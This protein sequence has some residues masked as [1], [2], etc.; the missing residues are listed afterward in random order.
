M[1]IPVLGRYTHGRVMLSR[2]RYLVSEY[3]D[4][5]IRF[6]NRH[7]DDDDL[8]TVRDLC[9]RLIEQMDMVYYHLTQGIEFDDDNE[10][11]VRARETFIN[12]SGWLDGGSAYGMFDILCSQ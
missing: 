4:E 11:W 12:P 8:P 1:N 2:M 10:Q 3:G 7:Q 6:A 5:T 9:D